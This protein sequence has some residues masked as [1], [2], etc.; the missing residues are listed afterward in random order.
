M[1]YRKLLKS[2][3]L[4]M[5]LVLNYTLFAQNVITGTVI[6][7]NGQALPGVSIVIKG[8]TAGT[9]SDVDGK[10]SLTASEDATLVFSFIGMTSQE[11]LVGN[12]KN[13]EINLVPSTVGLDEVVVTALGI[14][15]EKKS[16][17]YSVSEVKGDDLSKAGNP[18]VVKSL[19]GRVSGVNFTSTSTDPTSSVFITIRGAT[20]L[21]INNSAA[22]SQPLYVVD[23]I[24]LGSA[25]IDSRNGADFGNLL[26]QLN[27]DDIESVSI[28]K[29]ASAGA[30]YG[31]AA[32]NGVI[33]IT[34]KSG[35]GGKKGIGASFNTSLFWDV[36]FNF[37]ETQREY[38]IGVRAT[39][40]L[41][42]QGY[43]WGGKFADFQTFEIDQYN[44]L[45]QR[46]ETK[47]LEAADE[48]RLQEF[49]Q[50]G[51]TRNYNVSVAGNYDKGSFRFGLGKMGNDGVMPNNRTD[52]FNANFNAEYNVTNKIKISVSGN[53]MGQYTPNKTSANSDVVEL[54]TMD[55]LAHLQPLKEMQNVWKTGFEGV[56]Q[57]SPYYKPDGTPYADN[58]YMYVYSEINTYRKD[59]FFSKAQLDIQLT[60]PLKLM[61]RTGIDY[62]GD[63]YEYK[64]AKDFADS[65]KRDGKYSVQANNGLTVQ[66]DLMFIWNKEFGKISTNATLGYNYAFSN[67][68]SYSANA[69]KLVR[70][71]DY[72]LS[73]AVAGT[74]SA[75]NSWGIGK[76]QSVYGTA[77]IGYANQLY[78]DISG[79]NDWSGIL[80]EDKNQHFY[81]SAALSWLPSTTFELPEVISLLKL[82]GGIAQVGHGIGKPRSN[83]TFSFSPIDYGN[84][85]IVN[86][87]GSLVDPEILPEITTSFEG[88]FDIALFDR[89]ISAEF[90]AFKK[91]HDNQQGYI[92]TSPGV[93]Y[94]GMLTNV[95][96]VEAKG[97]EFTLNFNPVRTKDW[98]WDLGFNFTTVDSKITKLS[99]EYVPNGYT[100]YGHGPNISLRLA[101]GEEIGTLWSNRTF[102]RMPATSKYA[103][104]LI[105]RDSGEDWEYSSD[106]K[107]REKI[108]NYNPDF[109]L[110]TNTSVRWRNLRLG[111]VGSLRYGG[112]YYND[113]E[114]RAVTNGHS[115][116]TIGD[117]V[118]GPNDYVVGG[119]DEATGGLPWP[120]A[121]DMKY[122]AMANIVS[123]YAKYGTSV[124]T[125]DACYFKGVWLI[126]GGDPNNDDDYIVN[127]A[128]PL[129][130]LYS[131]P[132]LVYGSQYWA[133]PQTLIHDATNFKLKEVTLDYTV[134]AQ[135][136]RKMK[137]ENLVVG[138][139]GRN[140]YQWNKDDSQSDPETAFSG[141]GQDQGIVGKAMPSIAS[142]GFKLS[143]EF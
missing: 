57:N 128:D 2:M 96:T 35:K 61:V 80:E 14:S 36:P 17:A 77:Q 52:R 82:R 97:Y 89:R 62:N 139:V 42:G 21:N 109:I 41:P 34:T 123:T 115:L 106:E 134:P 11:I 110:G 58:P 70:A 53:Y 98:N 129:A 9:I 7:D 127:G 49:M 55:F 100:F 28:L 45:T 72:S 133:F 25:G 59:N 78:L 4:C 103:G 16:L 5:M 87:G 99:P 112:Q 130:T 85:K 50:T 131:L 69:E 30:L 37:Y 102:K 73:N 126:P 107:D 143:F 43:D 135:Y 136:T 19:D 46:I 119:R 83:N 140:I 22:A 23:G 105:V 71:N 47:Y 92:P 124:T 142:Y 12:Q 116:L 54:L 90:T 76:S 118:N 111:L 1:M 75:S 138:F 27:P 33:M 121:S 26:S 137:I 10:F 56:L 120:N 122:Q 113:I 95:G 48:I 3:L 68:Y 24:P 13:L 44:T 15:R 91:T 88:G 101:E 74:L 79:R 66:N 31:S 114:R 104:M 60:N 65:D 29:G 132:G 108:G 32:G 141:I 117:L 63:N 51:A 40:V 86:I 94:G 84:T 38:G 67:G 18:N 81:P 6:D 8:T 20:S 39:S 64:R 93:G 125:N